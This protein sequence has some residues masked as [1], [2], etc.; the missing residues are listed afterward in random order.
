M[1]KS[2]SWSVWRIFTE[3]LILIYQLSANE[4]ASGGLFSIL[5]PIKQV[6]TFHM[7][8]LITL[9]WLGFHGQER[10][11]I[12]WV[13]IKYWAY[14]RLCAVVVNWSWAQARPQN[15]YPYFT[16]ADHYVYP[17]LHLLNMLFT[18]D[19]EVSTMDFADER[20]V[21]RLW[22]DLTIIGSKVHIGCVE[23]RTKVDTK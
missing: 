15:W 22:F 23:T 14:W 6:K 10:H 2:E 7:S 21:T 13:K 3:S 17:K 8:R 16:N 5:T 4:N 12:S 20:L 9:L 19:L 1:L 11:Q 18:E